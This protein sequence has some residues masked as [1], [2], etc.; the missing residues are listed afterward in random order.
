M[1]MRVSFETGK[2]IIYGKDEEGLPKIKKE[3]VQRLEGTVVATVVMD[4]EDIFGKKKHQRPCFV[5]ALDDGSFTDIDVKYCT[6]IDDPYI[7]E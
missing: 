1:I 4:V 2:Y 6:R 3:D 7:D 5:V